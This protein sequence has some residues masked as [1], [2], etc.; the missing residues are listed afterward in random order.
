MTASGN[1]ETRSF[2]TEVQQLL[3]L[4]IHSLYSNKEIFLRELISNSSDACD[5]LRFEALTNDSLFESDPDLFIRVESDEQA[6]TITITDNGIGMSREEVVENL[7]TIARSGTREFLSQMTGDQAKDSQLIGQFGVG[8]YSAFVVSEHVSVHTRRAGLD[9]DKGVLWTSVGEGEYTL[10][11]ETIAARGTR[12]VL[13]LREEEK[14]LLQRYRLRSIINKYADHISVP[15]QMTVEP[16]ADADDDTDEENNVEEAVAFETVNRASAFWARARKDI[17]D[18]EYQEFYKHLTHDFEAPMTW[19][20][21]RVEG[22]LEY[23]HLLYVPARAP[24]DLWDQDKFRGIKLYVQRVFI[25][26]DAQQLMPRYLRFVRGVID[27]N[28][29]PLNVSRELLQSSRTVDSIR[30]GCTRRVLDMLGQ[31]L[32]K[33]REQYQ[34]FW[35]IFGR[36][37]KEGVAEDSAN[38]QTLAGLFLFSSTHAQDEGQVS[39]LAQYV[40]RMQPE[41]EHIYYITGD[42]HAAAKNSPHIEVFREKGLEVLLLSDRVDEWVAGAIPEFDGKPLRSINRGELDLGELDG[43]DDEADKQIDEQFREFVAR[44]GSVLGE[45][46]EDVRISKRLKDSPACI[47]S[48]EGALGGRLERMLREAG[49]EVPSSKPIL[50]LNPTHPIVIKASTDEDKERFKRW[51]HLLLDQAILAEGGD[52]D[53]PAGFVQ[54]MNEIIV[55]L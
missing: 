42:T 50:E 18:E 34:S 44:V 6:G 14:E 20:H 11:D 16:A 26:D 29:L 38:A 47:V 1:A 23:T 12:V 32:E 53:D 43:K 8:F 51:S 3:H 7:G 21:R 10:D 40:E 9:A 39:T 55:S 2:Q 41:Q 22:K 19:S 17:K 37:L 33:D 13:K 30:A 5:K 49:Q 27:S 24:F 15:V 54:R 36:V 25:M 45:K 48:A 31:M 28:D 52:L 35:N 4:M 46:V